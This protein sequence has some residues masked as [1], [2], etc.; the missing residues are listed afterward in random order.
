MKTGGFFLIAGVTQAATLPVWAR[1]LDQVREKGRLLVVGCL[2]VAAAI[3]M[4]GPMFPIPAQSN[5]F[6][7]IAVRQVM[8]GLSVGPGM[9]G[10]LTVGDQELSRY[11]FEENTATKAAFSACFQA[12]ATLGFAVGPV[13]GGFML[14]SAGYPIGSAVLFAL[15][16]LMVSHL[17]LCL[18][19][20]DVCTDSPSCLANSC[21]TPVR[22]GSRSSSRSRTGQQ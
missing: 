12:A 2:L 20:P 8:L 13:Y 21:E 9:V 5:S 22:S 19:F 18:L 4:S 16:C 15:L 14:D 3:A 7:L 17:L 10:S 1:A 6:S 11:G